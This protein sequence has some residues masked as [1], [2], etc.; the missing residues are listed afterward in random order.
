MGVNAVVQEV[1]SRTLRKRIKQN[2]A[3]K[4]GLGPYEILSYGNNS[5]LVK[6]MERLET[7]DSH[8]R[9]LASEHW[10][11]VKCESRASGE[12]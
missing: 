12:V 10:L 3:R 7:C 6:Y 8:Q 9:G 1:L 11:R 4:L 2:L 5:H